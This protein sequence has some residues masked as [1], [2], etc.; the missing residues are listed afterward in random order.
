MFK[1][2]GDLK[3]N[4]NVKGEGH[5]LILIHGGGSNSTTWD[6]MVPILSREFQVYTYDIRGFGDTVRPPQPRMSLELWAEDLRMFMESFGLEKA[7]LGGWSL[8]TMILITF[9]L[10]HHAMIDHLILMGAA[11]PKL[12]LTDTSGMDR[13][14][15]MIES[16]ATQPEIVEQTFEWTK[17]AFSPYTHEH[18]PGAVE[19]IRQEHLRND[20]RSYLEMLEASKYPSEVEQL[21]REISCPTLIMVGDAD[22]RTPVH[23][24]EYLNKAIPSSYMKMVPNCGHFYG[25]EQPE[26]TS[27][28]ITNFVKAFAVSQSSENLLR[29]LPHGG[30]SL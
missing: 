23:M 10:K 18:N 9:A 16:G 8:G 7:S 27:R 1:Q 5:P 13:R 22:A 30:R 25:Y 17:R 24:A 19:K 11:D 4:Y 20:P 14:R 6:E 28:V 3:V 15:A 26:L 2:I 21:V 12:T 29:M